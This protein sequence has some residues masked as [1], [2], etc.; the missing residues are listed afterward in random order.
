MVATMRDKL[1]TLIAE[2]KAQRAGTAE[3]VA[4]LQ[5]T[6]DSLTQENAE[7]QAKFDRIVEFARK[8]REDKNSLARQLEEAGAS[9]EAFDEACSRIAQLEEKLG[10]LFDISKQLRSERDSYAQQLEEAQS[11]YCSQAEAADR[12]CAELESQLLAEQEARARERREL[13]AARVEAQE[14]RGRAATTLETQ[15]AS[16]TELSSLRQQLEARDA[17]V[18]ELESRVREL[19][20]AD[21]QVRQLES[22]APAA[23]PAAPAVLNDDGTCA[24]GGAAVF[25]PPPPP[26]PMPGMPGSRAVGRLETSEELASLQPPQRKKAGAGQ[27]RASVQGQIADEIKRGI[28][29]RRVAQQQQQQQQQ[30]QGQGRQSLTSASS[31]AVPEFVE[32]AHALRPVSRNKRQEE[33]PAV[34]EVPATARLTPLRSVQQQQ[35]AMSVPAAMASSPCAAGMSPRSLRANVPL[36]RPGAPEELLSSPRHD[37]KPASPRSSPLQQ[38]QQQVAASVCGAMSPTWGR[39]VTPEGGSRESRVKVGTRSHLQDQQYLDSL[40]EEIAAL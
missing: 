2:V 9:K 13:E 28:T 36:P 20:S 10:R 23:A 7:L 17:Q 3:T 1:A 29:L 19:A 31:S 27:E 18:R 30:G 11:T 34:P 37:S 26:P 40:L 21:A 39:A 38:Q 32:G 8:E 4:D 25:A 6:V 16:V 5:A 12:R 22:A 33:L 14:A 35:V 24:E 15:R